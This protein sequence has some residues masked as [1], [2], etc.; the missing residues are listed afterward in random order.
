MT[1]PFPVLVGW[2]SRE[3]IAYQVCRH[4]LLQHASVPVSVD[5]IRQPDLRAAGIYDRPI[6]PL[7]S[8]EFTYTRFLVPHL[9]GF[10]GWALFVDCD[11]LWLDDI[12]GLLAACDPR[13]AVMCVQH[14]YAP[15]ERW[16]M[17]G[18][19][20]SSYPRKNWSSLILWNCGH[21]AN[22]VLT[23]EL[24]NRESGAFL[25]RFQWLPDELIGAVPERWNWLEGWSR[26][27]AAG[28]L[29]GAVHYTRGG[30]WFAEWQDVAYAD[31]WCAARDACVGGQPAAG[32]ARAG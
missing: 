31:L 28:Q 19:P 12:A 17:D 21:P 2:D 8:T 7:A 22:R 6:D 24:V 10:E 27:A 18:V 26:P 16:K 29:P 15:T 4:S 9:R 3:D 20:Q 25:H 30:P 5:P 23:P 13:H 14:D 1:E 11:F 32:Q